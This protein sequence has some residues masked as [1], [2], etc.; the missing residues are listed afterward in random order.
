M[1]IC[2]DNEKRDRKRDRK[3][4]NTQETLSGIIE[5]TEIENA[6]ENAHE[7]Q[8]HDTKEIKQNINIVASSAEINEESKNKLFNKKKEENQ[9][10]TS[11]IK[12]N[13]Q[14]IIKVNNEERQSNDDIKVENESNENR[15][16]NKSEN[17]S[18]IKDKDNSIN[19]EDININDN[20]Y[21]SCPKCHKNIPHIVNAEYDNEK[22]DFLIEYICI[23]DSSEDKNIS[24]LRKLLTKKEPE[25][26]CINHKEKQMIIFCKN[27]NKK[28][29]EICKEEGHKEHELDYNDILSDEKADEILK[30]VG[31]KKEQFKG[32]DIFIKLF[33]K[34]KENAEIKKQ[35]HLKHENEGN[36]IEQKEQENKEI[37]VDKSQNG[38]QIYEDDIEKYYEEHNN[39]ENNHIENNNNENNN[40]NKANKNGNISKN[41]SE[42]K[43]IKLNGE[44]NMDEG[45]NSVNNNYKEIEVQNIKEVDSE[46]IN[47]I[48]QDKETDPNI[49]NEIENNDSKLINSKL[50]NV[51][52]QEIN[53]DGNIFEPNIITPSNNNNNDNDN[54]NKNK[55]NLSNADIEEKYKEYKCIKTITGHTE[56]VVTLIQLESGNLATGSYDDTICVWDIN[57]G[58][59]IVKKKEEGHIFCLLEFEKNMVLSSTN[60]NNINLWDLSSESD[61]PIHRFIGHQLWVN[62][63]V[64]CNDKIFASSG[65]DANIII[66]DYYQ[67]IYIS[68][69]QG[70][71]DCILT[72]IKLN[73]GKLCS[74]SADLTIKIWDWQ[75]GLC[76]AT[77]EEHKKWVKCL[78]QLKDGTLVSGSD[79]KTIKFWKEEKCIKSIK[80]HSNSIR[81]L[82]QINDRYFASG[83]FDNSIK[84]WDLKDYN[85]VQTLTE[86]TG[87][88]I[89]IIK[90]HDNNLASCSCDKTI[91]IWE[92][93]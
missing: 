12:S 44:N 26:K 85:C 73:D 67:R 35:N 5:G 76:V 14:K 8:K 28:I 2:G 36:K 57:N 20:Y 31:E 49:K 29:C 68:Y 66:W 53:L 69:L 37:S 90:L 40:E 70:H 4:D 16:E 88:I 11:E 81:A 77:L 18:N 15:S 56:K 25:D 21:I 7:Q 83:S 89:N 74:G 17:N 60:K 23:C 19:Y 50:N 63:L 13:D 30:I 61:N 24:Y 42:N 79:D 10:K 65:N 32:F 82:C 75:K 39:N 92:N 3:R 71:R 86:H 62:N 59:N 93:N 43:D 72:L 1:G 52:V 34:F 47:M 22:N 38:D 45:N 80:E 58:N 46:K 6:T 54:D 84:I 9:L 55:N 78:C 87:N 48:N 91:K 64:K 41:E 51:P 27:C 33:K